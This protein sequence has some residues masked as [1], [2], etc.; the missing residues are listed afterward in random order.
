MTRTKSL[1]FLCVLAPILAGLVFFGELYPENF[2]ENNSASGRELAKAYCASCHLFPEPNQLD[3][4]T[5]ENSV[6]PNMG[7]R[8]GIRTNDLDPYKNLDALDKQ[9]TEGLNIYPKNPIISQEDWNKI[10]KYYINEAPEKLPE[11]EFPKG[12]SLS[13][14]PFTPQFINIEESKLPK[15]SLLKYDTINSQLYIGDFKTLYALNASG[16]FNGIWKLNGPV[17]HIEFQKEANPIISLLGNFGPS[18]QRLGALSQLN[19]TESSTKAISLKRLQRPVYFK[20]ADI[21]M[22]GSN[23]VVVC[24]FGNYTG[25]LSW[26]QDY[27][28]SKEYIIKKLPGA[29]K[30][31]I[32]DIN[33]DNFPD[34]V[35]LMAQAY[36]KIIF[37]TNNGKG[38]FKERTILEFSPLHGASY[39]EFADFNKDGFH[40][41]LVSNGDNWD[42]SQINK[43]YHGLRIYLNDGEN[44]F[45]EKY[46]F[47]MYGC[48][49]AMARDFDNDGDLDIV[50]ASFYSDLSDPRQSFVYLENT[51][52]ML[53][54]YSFLEEAI[55]GKWLTMD[56][57]DFNKDSKPDVMLGSY[58]HN[59]QEMSKLVINSGT[60]TFPQVMLL[61]NQ[62]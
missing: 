50:A 51:G 21:N 30:I 29:R 20:T 42:L 59:I 19:S 43:P 24:N 31:E 57:G 48:S 14:L 16:E 2:Q 56:I 25:S 61:I 49:K 46:F 54:N 58:I 37:F 32:R 12:A 41:L 60:T 44:N 8:L 15:V 13:N 40:D 47:P 18:D 27:D 35:A 53:F 39:F 5:W 11:T 22:D 52:D 9:I 34:I 28:R 3:K 4:T 1:T 45:D 6:L 23:D 62:N 17:S 55:Y 38:E 33:G 36:E 10:V 7:M 26:Y